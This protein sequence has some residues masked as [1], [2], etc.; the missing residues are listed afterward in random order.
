MKPFIFI[1]QGTV[2]T[3][4]VTNQVFVLEALLNEFLI[5]LLQGFV[6]FLQSLDRIYY[7]SSSLVFAV[8]RED[9]NGGRLQLALALLVLSTL[10]QFSWGVSRGFRFRL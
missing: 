2:L 4:D 1:Q 10:R 9:R 3:A 5:G 7:L 8:L 6:L